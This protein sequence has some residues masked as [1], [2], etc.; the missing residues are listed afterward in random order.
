MSATAEIILDNTDRRFPVNQDKVS[1]IRVFR[2]KGDQ[3]FVNQGKQSSIYLILKLM[4]EYH[5]LFLCFVL[6]KRIIFSCEDISIIRPSV[7][8]AYRENCISI[9]ENVT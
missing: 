8:N 2:L 6:E 3:I 7:G 5:C 9:E 1:I 4:H